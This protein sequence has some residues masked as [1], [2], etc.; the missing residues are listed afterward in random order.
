[1]P[2]VLQLEICGHGL[3]IVGYVILVMTHRIQ[4]VHR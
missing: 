3:V 2:I 4:I 1:M